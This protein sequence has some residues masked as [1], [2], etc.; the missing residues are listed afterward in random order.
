MAVAAL[1]CSLYSE[2]VGWSQQSAY[3]QGLCAGACGA[4]WGDSIF[5]L[6]LSREVEPWS[7]CRGT[8]NQTGLVPE[9]PQARLVSVG[10]EWPA[11][12]SYA[13]NV[14]NSMFPSSSSAP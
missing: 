14:Q 3:G 11:S 13:Q 4:G 10:A 2:H 8:A 9:Q 5:P 1:N 6:G 12:P 7:R